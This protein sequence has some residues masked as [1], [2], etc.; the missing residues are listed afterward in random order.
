MGTYSKQMIWNILDE[1]TTKSRFLQS[2]TCQGGGLT[3]VL[4]GYS[5]PD[6]DFQIKNLLLAGN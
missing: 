3:R 6:S 2:P 1:R 4:V 5:N